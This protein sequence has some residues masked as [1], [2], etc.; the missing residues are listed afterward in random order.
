MIN[1]TTPNFLTGLQSTNMDLQS[2]LT[3]TN[4]EKPTPVLNFKPMSVA[5][6]T[7]GKKLFSKIRQEEA[8]KFVQENKPWFITQQLA[9]I[10]SGEKEVKK[11]DDLLQIYLQDTNQD[12]KSRQELMR[13]LQDGVEPNKLISYLQENGYTW[14]EKWFI[15]GA[16]EKTGEAFMWGLGRIKEAGVGIAEGKYNVAEWFARGGAGALESAFSP[17]SGVLWQTIQEWLEKVPQ[18]F[19]DYISEKAEP[20]IEDVKA[21]YN[22]QSPEQQRNLQN[23]GVWVEIL[24]NFIGVKWVQKGT[25]AVAPTI[26]KTGEQIAQTATD[27]GKWTIKTGEKLED[28]GYNLRNILSWLSEREVSA[29]KNTPKQEW[30][31]ILNQA[32]EARL[33]PNADYVQTPYHIGAKKAEDAFT[34]LE[35]NLRDN[36]IKRVQTLE[37]SW[38]EKIDTSKVRNNIVKDIKNTFNIENIT[39]EDWKAIYNPIKWR[40]A[41]LDSSNPRDL[42]AIKLLQEAT[43]AKSP[44]E[45]MDTISQMQNLIY[46]TNILNRT[47]KNMKQLVERSIWKLNNAFKEQVWW[48]YRNILKEMSEDIKLRQSLNKIFKAW[49]WEVGN[50]WELAMKRL[51]SGTTTSSDVRS[52][53]LKVKE[54]TGIDLIKEARLRQLAMDIV[55]DDRWETL[56]NVIW[57]WKAGLIEKWY[58]KIIWITPLSKEKTSIKRA[59]T[60]LKS[61]TSKNANTNTNSLAPTNPRNKKN[62][63]SNPV[64]NPVDSVR[65]NDLLLKE[66]PKKTLDNKGWYIDPIAMVEDISK[67]LKNLTPKNTYNIATQISKKLW[68]EVKKVHTILKEYVSKYGEKLKDKL[69]D[70]A[71]DIADKTGARA[72][73][74][75]DEG[76][77]ISGKIDAPK[78]LIE[79]MNKFENAED[80]YQQTAGNIRK[81]FNKAGLRYKSDYEKFFNKYKT[82]WWEKLLDT[83]NPTWTLFTEY[84]PKL[85]ANSKIDSSKI[86]TLADTAWKNPNDTITIYRGTVKSQKDMN[87]WDFVTTNYDLAKSYS[88]EGYVVSKKVKYS[89]ILDEIDEPLG[90]EYL[91]IPSNMQKWK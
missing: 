4:K 86:T 72:K 62:T 22:S 26:K 12:L 53:A 27:I 71:D 45:M 56:F 69:A 34:K 7:D 48:D 47:S 30:D 38:I 6:A 5:N 63:W 60:W 65:S 59:W 28:A 36:Q 46:D 54:K 24:S 91:Y 1:Q 90:E 49:E 89:D 19:K 33:S 67:V 51:A 81:E 78:E 43:V 58:E 68:V 75:W 66:A 8:E 87:P 2:K 79:H 82:D 41:L 31:S 44:L 13:A 42:E 88:G 70:L 40:K 35:K 57:R 64:D 39:I 11:E 84:T 83:I 23:I 20:T 3:Q 74:M 77:G 25:E 37:K 21:W 52:L 32:K 16:I 29:L 18:D 61:N 80:F 85:R 14:P 73:F 15:G 50:R 10:G 76:T 55:W 9:K 17:V